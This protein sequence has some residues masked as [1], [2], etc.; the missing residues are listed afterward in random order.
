MEF[1]GIWDFLKQYQ[2]KAPAEGVDPLG[3]FLP[4]FA[5][6]EMQVLG[7]AITATGGLDETKLAEYIHSHPFKTVVGEISFRPRRRMDQGAANLFV[8]Y[9]G[10]K[11]A[12][13]RAV[14]R[15]FPHHDPRT[16]RNSRPAS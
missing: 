8:Q 13:H 11:A 5:Y 6:A 7:E 1:P 14:P 10:I 2:P 12:R 3:Y 4:P 16:R 15:R 9:H